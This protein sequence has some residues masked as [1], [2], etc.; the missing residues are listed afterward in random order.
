VDFG[1]LKT[2]PGKAILRRWLGLFHVT[3]RAELLEALEAL[4]AKS[5][6]ALKLFPGR[7]AFRLSTAKGRMASLPCGTADT[8]RG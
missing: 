2:L 3:P 4:F 8:G 1:D 6:E 7:Y 5:G